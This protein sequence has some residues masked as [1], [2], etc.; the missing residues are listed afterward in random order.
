M[1]GPLFVAGDLP[2]PEPEDLAVVEQDD[3]VFDGDAG[4]FCGQLGA[5]PCLL[6]K[7][8]GDYV[9][10]EVVSSRPEYCLGFWVPSSAHAN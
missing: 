5:T 4:G 3:A 1:E 7:V 9:E 6:D 2:C 8:C 10:S